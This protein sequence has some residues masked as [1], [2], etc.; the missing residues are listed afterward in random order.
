MAI[1]SKVE[2][3]QDVDRLLDEVRDMLTIVDDSGDLNELRALQMLL[4]ITR[5]LHSLGNITDVI[6][7][8]L[9]SA[10]AFVGAE[11]AFAILL[12]DDGQLHFKMGRDHQGNYL[13]REDFSPSQSVISDAINQQQTLIVPNALEDAELSKRA[14]VQEMALRTI[15]CAPL[16]IKRTVIGVLYLDS[17]TNT[18]IND[19]RVQ[20]NVLASLA[21][22]S[23]VAIRNA[24]KFETQT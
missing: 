5:E 6:T 16:M 9:D 17:R 8:V 2:R 19:S 20:V 10:L 18:L 7:K 23:A 24:Q 14:S 15:I 21:D 13:K 11:R 3:L 4:E 22:Q 12:D 1:R